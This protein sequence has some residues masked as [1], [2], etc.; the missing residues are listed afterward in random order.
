MRGRLW[1]ESTLGQG[2][3]FHFTSQMAGVADQ[4]GHPA[5]R[6]LAGRRILV[7]VANATRQRLT[8]EVLE[9]WGTIP[10]EVIGGLAALEELRRASQAGEPYDVAIVDDQLGDLSG[11]DLI[12][13]SQRRPEAQPDRAGGHDHRRPVDRARCEDQKVAR[14]VAK[15]VPPSDLLAALLATV[16]RAATADGPRGG[17][18]RGRP[19]GRSGL[20]RVLRPGPGRPRRRGSSGSSWPRTSW[21]TGRSR[22]GCWNG[23]ATRWRRSRTVK[24]CWRARRRGLR[25]GPDGHPDARHGRLRGGRGDPRIA[26]RADRADRPDGA[27]DER[28]SRALPGRRLRR[29]PQQADPLGRSSRGAR[30]VADPAATVRL[31]PTP[32]TARRRAKPASAGRSGDDAGRAQRVAT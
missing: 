3:V 22:P 9:H 8:V 20:P 7:A 29:L 1:V 6:V 25:R 26:P 12:G 23:S 4:P 11:F 2:S 24:R 10:R 28:G 17:S 21:S 32:R 16:V 19:R 31:R 30:S 15:P 18:T 14:C 27:R 13:L 5:R